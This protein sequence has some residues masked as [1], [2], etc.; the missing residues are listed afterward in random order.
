MR[1]TSRKQAGEFSNFLRFYTPSEVILFFRTPSIEETL[2]FLILN[3]TVK[4]PKRMLASL[5]PIPTETRES[6]L[7]FETETK[8]AN[9]LI[10]SNPN[11]LPSKTI[12]TMV[13]LCFI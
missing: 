4:A 5:L 1:R 12:F 8:S 13:L 3:L 9:F 2:S 7:I 10:P 6:S 11:A